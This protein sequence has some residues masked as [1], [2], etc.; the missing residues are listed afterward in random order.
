MSDDEVVSSLK[1]AM[2]RQANRM[3]ELRRTS[4]LVEPKQMDLNL[5]DSPIMPLYELSQVS[6]TR[7]YLRFWAEVSDT[8]AF[9]LPIIGGGVLSFPECGEQIGL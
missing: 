6:A 2:K 7:S 3:A 9:E 4:R 1:L 5:L 8:D